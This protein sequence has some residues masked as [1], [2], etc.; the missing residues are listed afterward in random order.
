MDATLLSVNVAQM[1]EIPRR[2]GMVKTGIWKRPVEGTVAVRGVNLE[3]DDQGDR[4]VH[5]GPHKAVYAYAREDV[6][7]WEGELDRPLPNGVF[8]ENLTLCGVDVTGA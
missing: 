6:D 7:W 5:G 2:G 8:G 4:S 3:G 1:R